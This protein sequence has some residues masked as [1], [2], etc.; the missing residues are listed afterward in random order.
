MPEVTNKLVNY[1][2]ESK[3]ELKKVVWP[4]RK[5]ATNHTLMVIGISL[6]VAI[7]FGI[8]DYIFNLGLEKFISIK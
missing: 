3:N 1:V 5:E 2:K 4:S 6:G 7:L 8:L